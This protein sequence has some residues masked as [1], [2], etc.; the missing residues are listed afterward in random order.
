MAQLTGGSFKR[1]SPEDIKVR[2]ST[3]NQLVDVIQEDVSGSATRRKYQ[4]FVTGGVGPGITSSLFQTVYDQDFSLQTAN[5]MCDMTVGLYSS[6]STVTN[7]S[8]GEDSAGKLLFPSQSLMMREKVDVYKQYAANLLGDADAAFFSPF[9]STRTSSTDR[10]SN[11]RIEEAL[12]ISYKRLFARDKIKRET[13]A[14]RFYRSGALDGSDGSSYPNSMTG[15]N[16]AVTSTSGSAIFSDIGAASNI[17]RTFGGEVGNI[18]NAANTAEN[19]GLIFYDQGTVVL[20]LGKATFADQHMSGAIQAMARATTIDGAVIPSGLTVLGSSGGNPH[21]KFVPDFMVSG[22]IDQIVDHVASTRFQSGS[23]TSAT[24]QNVTNINSTLI[25]CRATA[26]EFNYSTNPTFTDSAGRIR[27]VDQGQEDTQRT[28][29]FPTTVGL[30]DEFGNL[31]AVAKM[32]RPI[33][34]NDEK[35]ITFRIRLD[36]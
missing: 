32:S 25:F 5:A 30:H 31:L 14:T 36:F 2:R 12:F 1:I 22:S 33:E 18:V 26:D 3:L 15:S 29:A 23:L 17:R 4:V 11:D 27:V 7:A 34:K 28:F 6:G 19:V 24:F 21:A 9:G 20:D 8:T 10:H 16:I 35:D 13:F